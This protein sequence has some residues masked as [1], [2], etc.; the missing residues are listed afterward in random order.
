MAT[1]KSALEEALG[2]LGNITKGAKRAVTSSVSNLANDYSSWVDEREEEEKRRREKVNRFLSDAR[3][4]FNPDKATSGP[5][6]WTTPTAQGL[7]NVQTSLTKSRPAQDISKAGES[8][9]Q[10]ARDFTQMIKTGPRKYFNPNKR[11]VDLIFGI[12]V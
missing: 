12:L 11:P 5:N 4:Y 1:F 9:T 2:F 10:G 8:I 6:F 7:A 3:N